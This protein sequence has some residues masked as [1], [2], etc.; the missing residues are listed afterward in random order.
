MTDTSAGKIALQS[1][2]QAGATRYADRLGFLWLLLASIFR[3][4]LVQAVDARAAVVQRMSAGVTRRITA[5]ME[6]RRR[7]SGGIRSGNSSWA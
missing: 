4:F 3:I 7:E 2:G 6:R 1:S 5:V